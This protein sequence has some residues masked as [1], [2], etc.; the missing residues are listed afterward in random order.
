MRALNTLKKI[1]GIEHHHIEE[2]FLRR[3]VVTAT[4]NL[5][6]PKYWSQRE[7]NIVQGRL[8]LYEV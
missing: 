2:V 3:E 8:R 6:S 4:L 7:S 5:I 1:N